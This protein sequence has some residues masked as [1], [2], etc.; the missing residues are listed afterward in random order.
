V[1]TLKRGS[2]SLTLRG[3]TD[4]AASTLRWCRDVV[5]RVAAVEP[6]MSCL[7]DDELRAMTAS[8]RD[9]LARGEPMDELLPEA[10]AVVREAASRS[11][12]QRPFDVQIMGGAVL[13]LGKIAEMRTGEGK[14]LTA[15]LPAYLHALSGTGV[16]VMTANDYLASRDAEWMGPVYRFLG[17]TV[18]LL[19]PA[20]PSDTSV[21]RTEY[22][23][24]VTYGPWSEF[25][26]DYLRDNLAWSNDDVIQRGQHF[27]IVDEADL[28]LIDEMRS[29]LQISAPAQSAEQGKL[30]QEV[31]ARVAQHLQPGGHYESDDRTRTVSLTDGGAEA[32]EDELGIDNL[33]DEVHLPLVHYVLNAL[34]AKEL[35]QKDR[36]YI[37]ADGQAVIIDQTSGR[38]H[39][40]RRYGEGI[41]EAIEA[42]EGL[43]I[44]PETETLATVPM[45][46]YLHRYQRLAGLT[47]TAQED[48]ETYRQIYRLE[49]VTIPTNKPMI[50][51]DH[52]D[53]LYRTR[54]S[55]LTALAEEVSIRHATGQ[56]VLVGATS[57][58][59][60]RAISGLLTERG[61]GHGV[62]TALNFEQEARV[63]ADAGELGAV[64]VVAKMA[65][66]GVDI[67][68]GG[69]DGAGRE[70]VADVGGLCVLGAER[71]HR[72]RLEMHLRGRAG[73]QG[74]PGEA[75]FFVSFDDELVGAVLR[76]G[77]K[78]LSLLR[79][80]WTEGE[81]FDRLATS[82][83]SAQARQAANEAAGLVLARAWDEVVAD[84]QRLIY[85]ERLPAAR[86]DDMS[87]QTRSLIEE[88]MRAV[89][90]AAAAGAATAEQLWR[91]LRELYP[92][93][94]EPQAFAYDVG[95][96][97]HQLA[98]IAGLVV[99]DAQRAYSRR[100]TELGIGLIRRLERRVILVSLDR[101]WREHLQSMPDLAH[102][103]G[104]R[105][106][107]P[108][109]LAEYR[110]EGTAM[111]N[112]MREEV[113]ERIVGTLFY[114]PA[115]L[116]D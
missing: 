60:A 9:R 47:G 54:D 97:R 40:G 25:G 14:T 17:L 2:G 41:H 62:L 88:V 82:L 7:G 105:A 49:V 4:D 113:N 64:T 61:I 46:D 116:L 84:Q 96:P 76:T 29:P 75:K 83:T 23:A 78:Q 11:V 53:A 80:I 112:R 65:G 94:L 8:F 48:A 89:V 52:A 5:S 28:I 31:S 19:Q 111:F 104:I 10:F 72:R 6:R 90:A 109:A 115:N 107:G 56:P 70:R 110:R 74:D 3:R 92:V 79:R 50:R 32:V 21:R 114:A 51:F 16:H 13:H 95:I 26:Y 18:G 33:Y 63:I 66:R 45:W 71:P 86:G 99:D 93:G 81:S 59:E 22:N 67:I 44:R 57:V 106:S 35:Y 27:V 20:P 85:A 69:T 77:G 15:T 1:A 30:W 108:T 36:D 39:R 42:K 98:R 91:G 87:G 68:L 102:S 55:K 73:R 34:K 12:G 43:E 38:L 101:G 100:E 24:D 37:V 58:E 103:I